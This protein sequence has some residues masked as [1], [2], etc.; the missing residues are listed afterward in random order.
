[1]LNA[2]HMLWEIFIPFILNKRYFI[3]SN[4]IAIMFTK[5]N[6]NL[7]CLNVHP[8]FRNKI[9]KMDNYTVSP[10]GML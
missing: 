6:V 3:L 4:V 7:Q 2:Y 9:K 8:N 5:H 1:V 10:C